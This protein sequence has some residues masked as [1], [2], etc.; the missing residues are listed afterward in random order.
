MNDFVCQLVSSAPAVGFSGSRSAQ[1]D[2]V[3]VETLAFICPELVA[4]GC[5][6]GVDAAFRRVLPNAKIFKVS[7]LPFSGRGAFA[8]RSIN[9][10]E[11]VADHRG[12]WVSFPSS[13]C[14]RGLLPSL[15]AFSGHGSGSWASLSYAIASGLKSVVYLGS[16]PCPVGW[17]LESVGGGWFVSSSVVPV[18]LSVLS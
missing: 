1:P 10:I 18:Q 3:T 5:A 15:K 9:C 7:D 12:L 11:W 13:E 8:R 6:R 2:P 4:I 16:I 17:G 14:P